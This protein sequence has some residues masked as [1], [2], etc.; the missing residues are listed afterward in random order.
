[1]VAHAPRQTFPAS[2]ITQTQACFSDTSSPTYTPIAALL[3][4]GA[5]PDHPRS[6]RGEQRPELPHSS[7]LAIVTIAYY[8][9]RATL[10]GPYALTKP[11]GEFAVGLV[12]QP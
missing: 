8:S 6:D 11:N 9:P 10:E 3:G 7:F 2:T 4:Q 12:A 1:M 5:Q